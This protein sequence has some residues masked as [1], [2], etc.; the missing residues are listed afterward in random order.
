ME[1]NPK[2]TETSQKDGDG[3]MERV[4]GAAQTVWEKGRDS[5]KGMSSQ[6]K[7][8]MASA[9]HSA[10]KTAGD[11][12]ELVKKHPGK[13]VGIALAVGAAIGALF[14]FRKKE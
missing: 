14:A 8:A 5:W 12:K 11:A 1:N 3:A 2:V 10:K 13:A 7:E 6:G 9:Q 4:R